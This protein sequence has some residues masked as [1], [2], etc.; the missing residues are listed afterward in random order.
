MPA[1][2]ERRYPPVDVLVAGGGMAGIAAAIAAA[3][4]GASTCLV[5]RAGW[6]GGIG[7]TGATGLHSFYNVFGG[8]PG[9]RSMRVAAGVAQELVDR[10]QRLG[11]GVG[12][13]P[14]ERGAD[15]VSMLTP[16][17][18]EVFKL[19]A[20]Q[21][22]SEAGV[23][24]LLHTIVDEVRASSGHVEGLVVW[25]K[26]GRSL[27]RARR[28]VDCTG[29]GDLA[30]WAGAPHVHYAAGDPGAYPIGFTF[31]LC[32]LDLDA[33]EADLE[34]R[35]LIAQLAHAVKPGT[36]RPGLVRLAI[37]TRRLR[38]AGVDEAPQY[39]ISTSLRPRELT[40]C[41][42]INSG[43]ADGLDPDA[44][45]AA[46]ATL[47]AQMFAVAGLFR[48]HF[49]GC[50]ECSPAGPAPTAGVRRAVGDVALPVDGNSCCTP[51]CAVEVGRMLEDN[52]VCHFEEPCYWELEWTAEVTAALELAVARGA[53]RTPAWLSGGA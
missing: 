53:N 46:E 30:A 47:R 50:E 8:R 3:R 39:F 34:R 52:G 12:H 7:V 1:I 44:L 45:A 11:G 26:A 33:L 22:C 16:V 29:D 15:F 18:P 32:N 27:L 2:D 43:P 17:E 36:T 24:L 20:V 35:G 13:V 23:R 25:N 42:C 37:D 49:A 14:M 38:E 4:R 40:H 19:A 9:A 28:Y 48:R 10:V 21:L 41:N 31:R 51:A 6:L 5:E